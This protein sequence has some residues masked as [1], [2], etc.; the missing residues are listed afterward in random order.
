MEM[1]GALVD[2]YET[3]DY[4]VGGKEGMSEEWRGLSERCPQL[5]SSSTSTIGH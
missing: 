1:S 4:R 2:L 3:T 5:S